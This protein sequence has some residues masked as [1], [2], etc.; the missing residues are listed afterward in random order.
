MDFITA[1]WVIIHKIFKWRPILLAC[2][3][4]EAAYYLT[5]NVVV[6]N[7]KNEE[8]YNEP[9][10]RCPY[11]GLEHLLLIVRLDSNVVS[12]KWEVETEDFQETNKSRSSLLKTAQETPKDA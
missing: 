1:F 6:R 10:I 2:C 11:C 3:D 5:K 12:V 4:C 8:G 9:I 7:I